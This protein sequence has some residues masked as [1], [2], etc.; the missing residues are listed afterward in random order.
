MKYLFALLLLLSAP[1]FAQ[2]PPATT[3]GSDCPYPDAAAKV[4]Q[5]GYTLLKFDV[6][7]DGS[8]RNVVVTH[9]SGYPELDQAALRCVGAWRVA[10]SPLWKTDSPL[11]NRWMELHMVTIRWRTSA[12]ATSPSVGQAFSV[13]IGRPH[14]CSSEY[15]PEISRRLGEEGTTTVTFRITTEGT[16]KDP[17]ILTSSGSD[18]LDQAALA[19]VATWRYEPALKEGIPIEVPWKAEVVWKAPA[20]TTPPETNP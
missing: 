17:R 7:P 16:V 1:A 9:S 18:R 13:S 8:L 3:F 20:P 19:C 6:A 4:G 12:S 2:S 10:D 5:G 14:V 15:Y 11:W